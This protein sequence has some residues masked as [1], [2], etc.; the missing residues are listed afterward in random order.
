MHAS[1]PPPLT[2][3]NETMEWNETTGLPEPKE[4]LFLFFSPLLR[5]RGVPAS[6]WTADTPGM[7]DVVSVWAAY[8]E[9][10]VEE[11]GEKGVARV[12]CGSDCD[13][14]RSLIVL[15]SCMRDGDMQWVRMH[16]DREK[17]S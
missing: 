10:F 12:R 11:V 6:A 16:I 14:V 17:F 4:G 2:N 8:G 7:L 13:C 9:G 3:L 1:L 15:V 5:V